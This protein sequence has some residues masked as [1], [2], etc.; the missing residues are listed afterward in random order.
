[1]NSASRA[2][3]YLNKIFNILKVD[4]KWQNREEI[5]KKFIEA[6]K[7]NPSELFQ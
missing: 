3:N 4:I 1:M 5:R 7:Y 6:R 2:L